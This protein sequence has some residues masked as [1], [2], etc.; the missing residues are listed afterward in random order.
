[1]RMKIDRAINLED[2]RKL[3]KRRL[4]KICF[5][6]IEGGV[7]D[8]VGLG[9][10]RNAFQRYALMPRYL[11]D[12][13]KRDQSVP[14][15][16]HTYAGPFGISPTGVAELFRHGADMML[17]EAAVA[18]NIPFCLSTNSQPSLE[19][20]AKIAPDHLWPQIYGSHDSNITADM[21]KRSRDAGLKT[22]LL[23]VD[24]PIAPNRE[25]NLRN[26][27]SRPFKMRWDVMLEALTHPGWLLSYYQ[28]GG[29]PM[30]ENWQP[31]AKPGASANDVAD[32]FGSQT[33][34]SGQT[35]KVLEMVRAI[36]PGNLVVKGIMHPDDAIRA[37][38]IGANGIVVSNH[39]GRQLDAAPSPLEVFPS[40]KA[41]VG[42]RST[43]MLES[44]VRR[45]SDIVIALALGAKFC[46]AGRP[47]LYGAAAAGS[48][49]VTR[50]LDIVRKEVDLVMAQ[51]GCAKL[52]EI[53]PEYLL[54]PDTRQNSLV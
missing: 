25:R 54:Q 41:A 43:L 15:F 7:D 23:T 22:L 33:P 28:H 9:R 11:V 6:F 34:A 10:N 17:A 2:V 48:A 24:V 21:V 40:I 29:L 13:S 27:F 35:W 37:T 45:G 4:P 46:F 14:L 44:G 8:E 38:N 18:A 20:V 53:G 1:M 31:Y 3:A 50:V 39:G 51:I 36:W 42:E 52:S 47:T 32:F 49:G 5:D 26:G 19:K 16:G 30:M 12:V